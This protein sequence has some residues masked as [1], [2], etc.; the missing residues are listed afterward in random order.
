MPKQAYVKL[1]F[2][3]ALQQAK[4]VRCF[5]SGRL[6]VTLLCYLGFVLTLMLTDSSCSTGR[7]NDFQ[8]A[9]AFWE[10]MD[11]EEAI[12]LYSKAIDSG[13]LTEDELVASHYNLATFYFLCFEAEESI[14]SAN[15]VLKLNPNHNKALSLRA[16]AQDFLHRD[17][18]ALADWAKLLE[19]NP[20]DSSV[21]ND[22]SY[23]YSTRGELEKAIADMEMYLKLNPNSPEQLREY[24]KLKAYRAMQQ[25]NKRQ[26]H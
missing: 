2:N 17:E 5:L 16:L 15:D 7:N 18:Q 8:R 13:E 14:K 24:G 25:R 26:G 23:F 9:E 20:N 22:R 6:Q 12:D 4:N 19:L 1:I 3:H 10:R 11:Y 21:Y